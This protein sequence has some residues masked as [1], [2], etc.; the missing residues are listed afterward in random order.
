MV[1]ASE[2]AW[3]HAAGQAAGTILLLELGLVLLI[4]AALMVGFAF[5]AWWVRSK[6]VP[7]FRERAPQVLQAMQ[8]AQQGTDRVVSGV[9]EFYG[10]RQQ[11]ETTLRVLLFGRQAAERVHEESLVRAA[12]HLQLMSPPEETPGPENGFTPQP[13]IRPAEI[14]PGGREVAYNAADEAAPRQR[15]QREG[16]QAPAGNDGYDGYADHNGTNGTNGTTRDL[17]SNAG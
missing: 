10:R 7:V 2:P 4:V 11:A 1:I 6:V 13:R 17:A 8:T 5:A 14:G 16:R 12:E 15:A 3:L 9:A